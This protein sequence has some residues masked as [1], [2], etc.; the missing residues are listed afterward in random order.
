[1]GQS[2]QK[3]RSV[4]IVEDDADLRSLM[5]TLFNW[6]PLSA[7]AQKLRLQPCSSAGVRSP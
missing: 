5:A 7:K 1:M 2:Q 4:L 3:R 6:T